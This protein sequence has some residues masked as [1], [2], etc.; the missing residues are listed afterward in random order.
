[1]YNEKRKKCNSYFWKDQGGFWNNVINI[2]RNIS[3]VIPTTS[4]ESMLKILKA[5]KLYMPMIEIHHSINISDEI[6]ANVG[7]LLDTVE[8]TSVEVERKYQ[9]KEVSFEPDELEPPNNFRE[10]NV[11]PSAIEVTSPESPFLRPNVIKGPYQ[12]VNHYL[13]V[14]FRLLREDFVS[15]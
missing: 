12:S 10:I 4:C 2:S 11:Y 9:L 13:D 7:S 6:K 3:N 15:P 5:M 8:K 1:M 14:Q